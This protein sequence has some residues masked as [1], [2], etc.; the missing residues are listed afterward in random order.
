MVTATG[1]DASTL[2]DLARKLQREFDS[3]R[4]VIMRDLDLDQTRSFW[5][6]VDSIDRDF[7]NVRKWRASEQRNAA[8]REHL[9]TLQR[10]H[11]NFRRGWL[12]G[13]TSWLM[14]RRPRRSGS[15]PGGAALAPG[16][17]AE[18]YCLAMV[19]HLARL[20]FGG[21]RFGQVRDDG[22]IGA[23]PSARRYLRVPP[24]LWKPV[25]S[26]EDSAFRW[27]ARAWA[28]PRSW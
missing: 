5:F 10:I 27:R 16:G 19:E 18:E 6:Q 1:Q 8:L 22:L 4:D 24:A 13:C 21:F 3:E 9:A 28:L 11:D 15:V 25:T 12:G 2:N 26:W 20:L 7:H 23:V 14:P 17:S